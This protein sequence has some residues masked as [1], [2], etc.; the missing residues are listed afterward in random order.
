MRTTSME[1]VHRG[2]ETDVWCNEAGSTAHSDRCRDDYP[3]GMARPVAAIRRSV[4]VASSGTSAGSPNSPIEREP[5]VH[6]FSITEVKPA[7]A[8]SGISI[9]VPVA[10]AR[11]HACPHCIDGR[12][13]DYCLRPAAHQ[14]VL[15]GPWIV[16]HPRPRQPELA[17]L[18][19]RS[20]A[21]DRPRRVSPTSC[22]QP[23][24]SRHRSRNQPKAVE[25]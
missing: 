8:S 14:M 13:I 21:A 16:F 1:H 4:A 20:M 24:R 17:R 7:I 23:T 2:S 3:R 11:S 5:S 15:R 19:R 18:R 22:L 12:E 25:S 10:L 9:V 6:A